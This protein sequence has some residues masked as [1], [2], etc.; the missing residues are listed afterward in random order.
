M[1]IFYTK[2]GFLDSLEELG[3]LVTLGPI[4]AKLGGRGPGWALQP[5]QAPPCALPPCRP[6]CVGGPPAIETTLLFSSA[7]PALPGCRGY[8]PA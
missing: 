2:I 8:L 3:Y 6:G 5:G 1:R 7:G 4:P